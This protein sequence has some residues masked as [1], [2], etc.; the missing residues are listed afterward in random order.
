MSLLVATPVRAAELSTAL[1]SLGYSDF[2]EKLARLMPDHK[3]LS[4][5]VTF[6]LDVVRAR[7]RLVGLLLSEP[8][9]ANVTHILWVDDDQWPEDIRIVPEMV[10]RCKGVL[11]APYTN[12]KQPLRWVHRPDGAG[13][14]A[15]VGFGFT[16]TTRA[17]IE[18]LAK[19][20]KWYVDLPQALRCPN[21]FGQLF[22]TVRLPDGSEVETLLSEDFS[23]CKRAREAG[24][25]IELYPL[26]GIISHAGGHVWNAY[27]MKG[28]VIG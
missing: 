9:F 12:K 25:P 28:G 26:A 6:S 4:G 8:D 11:G 14:V 2:R 15:G 1:V 21:L 16:M 17:M 3:A 10:A 7:N 5:S 18:A 24:Y 27:E 20:A 23:F 13:G 19:D 22:E